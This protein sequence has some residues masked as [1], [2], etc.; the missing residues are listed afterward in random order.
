MSSMEDISWRTVALTAIAPIA[1]GTTYVVTE[2]LLPPDRP[3]F[4]ATM[5]ALPAGLLLLA[6]RRQLPHGDWWWRALLLGVCNIGLFS[7]LLFLSAYHLPGGLASTLQAA[8]PLVVMLLAWV[9]LRE[10]PAVVAV[11]AAVVGMG[12]VALL[13]L[14]SPGGVETIGLIGAAGSVLVSAL[15]FVLIKRWPAPVDM[16]TLVSWQLVVGGLLLLPVALLVEGPPPTLEPRNVAGFVWLGSVG[17]V[18][19]YTC[20]FRG[21]QRMPAGAVAL[22]GLV[23]PVVGTLLGVVVERELFGPVQALGMLLVLGGVVAGQPATRAALLGV[24]RRSA[25]GDADLVGGH[26]AVRVDDAEAVDADEAGLDVGGERLVAHDRRDRE[27]LPGP[28]GEFLDLE[29]RALA[30][31]VDA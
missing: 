21:L 25:D 28:V 10:R 20:W 8:S 4:A 18:V 7:P 31:R 2:Q 19:A 13:V 29:D 6:W 12:G 11:G 30:A 22:I 17:T 27:L 24:R 1:W 16:V 3:L 15:G 26:V 5:R 23:N 14:R 9:V